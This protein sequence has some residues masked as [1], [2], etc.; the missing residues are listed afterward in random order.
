MLAFIFLNNLLLE[1]DRLRNHDLGSSPRESCAL[2]ACYT[3]L[4]CFRLHAYSF[5]FGAVKM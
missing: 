3:F 5:S 4:L 2:H 1:A